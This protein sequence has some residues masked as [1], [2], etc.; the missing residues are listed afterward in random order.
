[1]EQIK[2]SMRLK[3]FLR[4][5]IQAKFLRANIL[6]AIFVTLAAAFSV[7][8]LSM[9]VLGTSLE[10]VYPPGLLK[11]IYTNLDSGFIAR[12]LLIIVAVVI[13]TFFISHRVAGPAYRIEQDLAI[14]AEGD[15]TKKIY[16]RKYDELKPIANKLNKIT[17][18]V[19][20]GLGAIEKN[21]ETMEKLN[22]EIRSEKLTVSLKDARNVLSK[23]RIK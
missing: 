3:Y 18:M 13:A 7:Y 5:G 10:E 2:K 14:M 1:M 11:E 23:F 19:N 17:D 12:L 20:E 22:E 6:L 8:Q 21:V 9:N 16:L 15:L 4:T